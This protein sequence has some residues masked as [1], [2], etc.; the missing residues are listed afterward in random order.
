MGSGEHVMF[1]LILWVDQVGLQD[2]KQP[3]ILE[4]QGHFKWPHFILTEDVLDE[5]DLLGHAGDNTCVQLFNTTIWTW[6]KVCV[7]HV[8]TL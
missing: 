4:A 6:T 2:G 5:V 1:N 7:G 3:T 8:I